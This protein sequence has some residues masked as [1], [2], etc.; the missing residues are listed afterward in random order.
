MAVRLANCLHIFN[1]F[2]NCPPARWPQAQPGVRAPRGTPGGG[3]NASGR[4]A[5][6][7]RLAVRGASL[8]RNPPPERLSANLCQRERDWSA[9]QVK[10][11]QISGRRL[12][13][14]TIRVWGRRRR[15]LTTAT[16]SQTLAGLDCK[17]TTQGRETRTGRRQESNIYILSRSPQLCK[18]APL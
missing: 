15:Q 18:T 11:T 4:V 2:R 12:S 3:L 10:R 6:T 17:P 8:S 1:L 7:R 16:P 13:P 5:H 14:S 9:L